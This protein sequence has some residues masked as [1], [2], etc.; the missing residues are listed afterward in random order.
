MTR[1]VTARV[2]ITA[3]VRIDDPETL[4]EVWDP[5]EP[6]LFSVALVNALSVVEMTQG[7]TNTVVNVAVHAIRPEPKEGA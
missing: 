4:V 1:P 7:I 2:A 6:G 3:D 5:E